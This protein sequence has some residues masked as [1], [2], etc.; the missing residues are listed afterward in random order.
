MTD[1]GVEVTKMMNRDSEISSATKRSRYREVVAA[2]VSA[3][4]LAVGG[5]L[6]WSIGAENDVKSRRRERF[7]HLGH[8]LLVLQENDVEMPMDFRSSDANQE[9][10]PNSWR[11]KVLAAIDNTYASLNSRDWHEGGLG[12]LRNTGVSLFCEPGFCQPRVVAVLQGGPGKVQA[13]YGPVRLGYGRLVAVECDRV[14]SCWMEAGDI[15]FLELLKE[16]SV[17]DVVDSQSRRTGFFYGVFESGEFG[18]ISLSIPKAVIEQWIAGEGLKF[19]G[20]DIQYFQ[21][22]SW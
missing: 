21:W 1:I 18:E 10:A 8:T 15:N 5:A 19:D 20:P 2:V 13:A 3:A 7:F 6:I 4:V 16:R 17:A 12:K 11:M 14:S 9:Q 22:R